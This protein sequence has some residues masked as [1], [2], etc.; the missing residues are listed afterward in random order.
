MSS[1]IPSWIILTNR[2]SPY[3]A[4]SS[5]A[6]ARSEDK[7][8]EIPHPPSQ[9]EATPTEEESLVSEILPNKMPIQVKKA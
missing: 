2:S 7:T 4:S 3:S 8:T 1:P 5:S 6:C 9:Q